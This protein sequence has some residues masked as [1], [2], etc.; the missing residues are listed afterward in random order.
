MLRDLVLQHPEYLFAGVIAWMIVAA[1]VLTLVQRMITDDVDLISGTIGISLALGLG[2]MSISPPKP[3]LQPLSIGILFLSG[4]MIP[5]LR[6]A[7]HKRELRDAEVEGIEKA[8]EGFVL[9]PN[10]PAAQIRMARH[11]YNLGVR[12]HAMK[13]ADDA[14]PQL[15]RQYFPDEHRMMEAWRHHPLAKSEFDP[16]ACVECGTMNPAGMI[17][18]SKCGARYLLHRVQGRVMSKSTGRRVLAGWIVLVLLIVGIPL[19]AELRE[20]ASWIVTI[21]VALV[22]TAIVAIAFRPAK[23]A[24]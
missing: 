9:R 14:L 13:L 4:I 21:V 15:P 11:L 7:Y 8:Y 3:F 18:C 1:W 10:N 2:Y 16:I 5:I 12:G 6:A 20:P 22:G 24:V 17:H 19:A 23:D